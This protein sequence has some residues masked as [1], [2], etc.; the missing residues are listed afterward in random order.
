MT[1]HRVD[2]RVVLV[3]S[4]GALATGAPASCGGNDPAPAGLV[5]G[6]ARKQSLEVDLDADNPGQWA[7]H[8]HDIYHAETGMMTAL[9]C[10]M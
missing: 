2:R 9:S 10:R 8:C 6:G 7:L 1:E 4:L 5:D 3:A